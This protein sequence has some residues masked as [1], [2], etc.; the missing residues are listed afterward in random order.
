[1]YAVVSIHS[2]A[3]R[4]QKRMSGVFYCSSSYVLRCNLLLNLNLAISPKLTG[5][6]HPRVPVFVHQTK[7]RVIGTQKQH[8]KVR[9]F[10]FVYRAVIGS[11]HM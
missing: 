7:A 1:M 3:C 9:T 11:T 4:G 2:H 10:V 6:Q 5:H 8:G